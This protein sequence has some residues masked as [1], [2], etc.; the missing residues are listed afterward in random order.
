MTATPQIPTVYSVRKTQPTFFTKVMTDTI[1]NVVCAV[2]KSEGEFPDN[3]E[4]LSL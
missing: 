2:E 3:F 1:G 4:L